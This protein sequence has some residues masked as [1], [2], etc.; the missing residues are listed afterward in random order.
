MDWSVVGSQTAGPGAIVHVLAD[1]IKGSTVEYAFM[2]VD[3][4]LQGRDSFNQPKRMVQPFEE[5]T[6]IIVA[7]NPGGNSERFNVSMQIALLNTIAA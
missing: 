7:I 4:F 1:K 2:I 6:T 5:G 3:S